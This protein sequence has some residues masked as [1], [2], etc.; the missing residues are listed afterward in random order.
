[1][2]CLSGMAAWNSRSCAS[3]VP[4]SFL[5]PVSPLLSL[6]AL[7]V[8]LKIWD[9]SCGDVASKRNHAGLDLGLSADPLTKLDV[10]N[11]LILPCSLSLSPH[12]NPECL[13]TRLPISELL[14]FAVSFWARYQGKPT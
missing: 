6:C 1:M 9:F 10:L 7:V 4:C 11:M 8:T 3:V 14:H 5:L 13:G 12:S 2:G